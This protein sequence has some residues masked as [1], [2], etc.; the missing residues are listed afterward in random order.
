MRTTTYNRNF[1][2]IKLFCEQVQDGFLVIELND[3]ITKNEI[4]EDLGN[5]YKIVHLNSLDKNFISS[6]IKE[7]N[8]VYIVDTLSYGMSIEEYKDWA[9]NINFNRDL[10]SKLGVVIFICP[11][12]IVNELITYSNSFWSYV[13]LHIDFTTKLDCIYSP[14]YIEDEYAHIE[15]NLYK[16][17]NTSEFISQDP[18]AKTFFL[19]HSK[20]ASPRNLEKYINSIYEN[21]NDWKIFYKQIKRLGIIL[22]KNF[23][24]KKA[25]ICF[26][27]LCENE[28]FNSLNPREKVEIYS[29]LAGINYHIR[30]YMH[31]LQF[32]SRSLYIVDHNTDS[33][34]D[35]KR[36]ILW[37]NVAILLCTDEISSVDYALSAINE[38]L[39]LLNYEKSDILLW[40]VLYNASL[41]N[42]RFGDYKQSKHLIEKAYQEI[43]FNSRNN[44]RTHAILYSKYYTIIAFMKLN[45][46]DYSDLLTM[47][48]E[49]LSLLRSELPETHHYIL[50]AHYTFSL[51]YLHLGVVDK[52]QKC[53]DKAL[54]TTKL[55]KLDDNLKVAIWSIYGVTYY[56]LSKVDIAKQYLS[57]VYN[58]FK[59]MLSPDKLIFIKTLLDDLNNNQT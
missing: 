9:I 31:S 44:S 23:Q 17:T 12:I 37:N 57:L 21:T 41:I 13:F 11:T 26:D 29:L 47:M 54:N 8:N 16:N 58:N 32:L 30:N 42:Y 39:H 40:E 20:N 34:S 52:A 49:S 35:F 28:N 27:F 56:Y 10:L 36:A 4:L 45:D 25:E 50:E 48:K 7:S 33:F 18:D 53:I 55:I 51:I 3:L 24:F 1:K 46:G 14:I 2:K 59:N 15:T 38:S 22:Y 43:N 6:N 5:L 19:H